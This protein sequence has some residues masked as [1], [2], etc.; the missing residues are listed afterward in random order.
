MKIIIIIQKTKDNN[1]YFNLMIKMTVIHNIH[2]NHNNLN[3]SKN[4]EQIKTNNYLEKGLKWTKIYLKI[5][6]MTMKMRK[7]INIMRMKI[8][9]NKNKNMMIYNLRNIK[10]RMIK[11]YRMNLKINKIIVL[12][13]NLKYKNKIV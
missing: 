1:N 2:N 7:M 9:I 11:I 5:L 6:I 3:N 4:K 8:I 10:W 12:N 13:R